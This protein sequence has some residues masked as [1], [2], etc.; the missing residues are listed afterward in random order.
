MEKCA[1]MRVRH[2]TSF[3]F[4]SRLPT[5]FASPVALRLQQPQCPTNVDGATLFAEE[6][7]GVSLQ[8]SELHEILVS[9]GCLAPQCLLGGFVASF[10]LWAAATMAFSCA[11]PVSIAERW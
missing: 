7:I 2:Q 5:R 11:L 3:E 4:A 6:H 9:A 8:E 1:A 10:R